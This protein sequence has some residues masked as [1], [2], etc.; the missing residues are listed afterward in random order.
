MT[1]GEMLRLKPGLFMLAEE[2]R[3][4]QLHPFALAALL[5]LR[6]F[7]RL[8]RFSEDLDFLL[9]EANPDFQ[10][11]ALLDAVHRECAM[12]GIHFDAQENKSADSA[13]RKAWL[14]TDSLRCAG[15]RTSS[16]GT[17]GRQGRCPRSGMVLRRVV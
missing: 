8:A 1:A 14:K 9:K 17:V 5:H 10:W 6:L 11:G 7:Y 15:A 16:A 12:E 2:W 13:V 4:S 3:K